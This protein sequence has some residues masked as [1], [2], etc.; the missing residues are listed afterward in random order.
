M[1]LSRVRLFATP[2]TIV[3]GILQNPGVVSAVDEYNSLCPYLCIVGTNL[4]TSKSA[5]VNEC[6]RI[7]LKTYVSNSRLSMMI[8]LKIIWGT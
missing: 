6:V 3:H 4:S 1:S 7:Y 5:A 2:W 8:Y